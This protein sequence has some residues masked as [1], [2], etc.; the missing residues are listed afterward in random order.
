MFHSE[1]RMS[2]DERRTRTAGGKR[3]PGSNPRRPTQAQSLKRQLAIVADREV[4]HLTF[5]EIA[6]K[7]GMG[8]KEVRAAYWRHVKEIAPLLTAAAP[9]ERALEYLRE[10]EN[11]R[12]QLWKLAVKRGQRQCPRR[13]AA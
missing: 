2:G 13:R 11:V 12:Q 10:L 9:D 4:E 5:A 7:H 6:C 8:E 3:R 1:T